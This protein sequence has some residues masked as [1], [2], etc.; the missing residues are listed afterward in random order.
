MYTHSK[1]AEKH[2]EVMLIHRN[3]NRYL[4]APE[5]M[6]VLGMVRMG[7]EFGLLAIDCHGAYM[8]VNGSNI[9]P[10]D[11]TR[12]RNAV[13]RSG[14][15]I[16]KIEHVLNAAHLHRNTTVAIKKRRIAVRPLNESAHT[17]V[18]TSANEPAY[19]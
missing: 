5:A 2:L 15:P 11:R 8:R 3:Q 18:H 13:R 17:S 9:V 12:V 6:E 16:D 1:A 14:A 4:I 19:A 7:M 10:L